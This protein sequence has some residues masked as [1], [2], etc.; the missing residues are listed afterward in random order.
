MDH[1]IR[2][3][4]RSD[5]RLLGTIRCLIR[6]WVEASGVAPGVADEVVLAIDEACSNAIRHSYEGRCDQTV[7]LTLRSAAEFLEF[8]VCDRGVP[9]PPEHF[10]RRPLQAPES[11]DVRPGGL[12]VQLMYEVFDEVRFSPTEG[13]GNCAVMRLKR[14]R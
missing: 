1:D 13:G 12:G 8:E 6:G 4:L 7:E 3:E 11:N 14:P 10:E 9:C 2:L 5:P